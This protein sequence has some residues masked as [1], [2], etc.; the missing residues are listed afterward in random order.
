M[1]DA[2]PVTFT[3]AEKATFRE[4]FD[5]FDADKSGTITNEEIG[6][7]FKALG[8]AVPAYKV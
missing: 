8:E 7:V 4:S 5:Q 3:E 6:E 2:K 1:T